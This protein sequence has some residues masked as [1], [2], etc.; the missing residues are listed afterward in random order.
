MLHKVAAEPSTGQPPF[1]TGS[2]RNISQHCPR[3]GTAAP[4][5]DHTKARRLDVNALLSD[6]TSTSTASYMSAYTADELYFFLPVIPTSKVIRIEKIRLGLHRL[7]LC[8]TEIKIK[9]TV[10]S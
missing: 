4:S 2:E 10:L 9:E 8:L 6:V 7:L 1:V 5:Q 3:S